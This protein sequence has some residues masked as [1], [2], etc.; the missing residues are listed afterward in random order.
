MYG[1]RSS[2]LDRRRIQTAPDI[3]PYDTSKCGEWITP[4]C[5]KTLYDIPNATRNQPENT[6]GIFAY[7]D[8]YDQDD[9][10][11]YWSH[12]AP[13]VPNGTH[14][15]L[16]SINGAKAPAPTIVGPGESIIDLDIAFALL[17]PQ[18]VTLYQTQSTRVQQ[19]VWIKDYGPSANNSL[20]IGIAMLPF[21]AALDGKLC[22]QRERDSGA[23]CGTIELTNVVSVSYGSSELQTSERAANRTCKEFMKRALKGHTIIVASGDYG[24]DQVPPFAVLPLPIL[25]SNGCE[26]RFSVPPSRM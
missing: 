10:N 8:V 4:A 15:N 22:T 24:V 12:Y 5:L 9:L 11:L 25:P 14:P 7:G 3:S 13:W 21:T 2:A 17:Y 18:E 23:D 26:S 16:Q 6:L 19:E 20:S 1:P